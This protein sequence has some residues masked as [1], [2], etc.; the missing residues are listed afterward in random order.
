MYGK[1]GFLQGWDGSRFIF[2]FGNEVAYYTP[3]TS[4]NPPHIPW[5]ELGTRFY[6]PGGKG[7]SNLNPK[8]EPRG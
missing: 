2:K 6:N 4:I 7:L 5:K 3:L 1:E 8:L